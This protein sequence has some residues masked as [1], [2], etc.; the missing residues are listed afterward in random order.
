M[1]LYPI[2]KDFVI[3]HRLIL[4]LYVLNRVFDYML[5]ATQNI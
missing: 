1:W 2:R 5:Y 3:R 4:E